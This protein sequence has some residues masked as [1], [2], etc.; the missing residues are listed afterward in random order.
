M[1]QLLVEPVVLLLELR[2]NILSCCQSNNQIHLLQMA[3]GYEVPKKENVFIN[4]NQQSLIRK[5]LSGLDDIKL[6][7]SKNIFLGI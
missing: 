5:A 7:T 4:Q 6:M 2:N 3:D 1:I